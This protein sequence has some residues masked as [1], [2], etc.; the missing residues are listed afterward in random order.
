MELFDQQVQGSSSEAV[1]EM[2]GLDV[3]ELEELV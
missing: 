1:L 3:L 2:L